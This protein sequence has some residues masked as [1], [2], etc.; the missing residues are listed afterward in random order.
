MTVIVAIHWTMTTSM[1]I[2]QHAWKF[3]KKESLDIS[4][5]GSEKKAACT[6][7]NDSIDNN[8]SIFDKNNLASIIAEQLSMESKDLFDS[9]LDDVMMHLIEKTAQNE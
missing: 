7:T 3:I 6:S 2:E 9:F 1:T 5:M 4:A 8:D